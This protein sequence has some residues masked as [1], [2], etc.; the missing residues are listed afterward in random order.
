MQSGVTWAVI[1][2]VDNDQVLGRLAGDT[3]D[4]H[5]TLRLEDY[6][7]TVSDKVAV[8]RVGSTLVVLG[9]IVEAT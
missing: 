4:I 6:T 5:L 1:T 3:R 9:K 8:A 7:P 2:V